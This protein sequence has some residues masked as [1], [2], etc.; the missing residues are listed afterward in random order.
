MQGN[1]PGGGRE[2]ETVEERLRRENE[3]LRH[4]LEALRV[5][6]ESPRAAQEKHWQPS[7]RTIWAIVL[8]L[9]MLLVIAFLAGYIPLQKRRALIVSEATERNEALPRAEVLRVT[10]STHSSELELPGSIQALTEAPL[11]ARADGYIKRRMV[12]IGDRVK[13]GQPLAEIEAPE[14]DEQVNQSKATLEQARAA[15]ESAIANHEQGKAN[16]ELAQ[17]TATRWSNLVKRGVVSKQ[18]NDLH[19]TEYQAQIANVRSLEKAIAAQRS[20]VAA[21]EANLARLKEM[22]NYRTVRAPFDGVIT[23]RNVDIGALVST[24]STLLFR[25]AQTET[26][27]IY[28]NVPQSHASSVRPGQTARLR[29]SNLPG[30]AFAGSVARTANSLDPGSRTMLVEVHVP[31]HDGALFPGMY[32]QVDLSSDRRNPPLLIP[33]DALVVL[34]EGTEVAKLGSGNEVH[35]QRVEVGRDYGDRLEILDGLHDGDIIIPNPGDLAREG[36]RVEPI[37]PKQ[38]QPGK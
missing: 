17:A 29:V 15:L 3:S 34:P 33:S 36:V 30:R 38:S 19:Q 8:L 25:V 35:L 24:G 7:G 14:L 6:P 10:R 28:V 1:I 16:L 21:A 31:N 20:N 32:A 18:D 5:N 22:S 4:Q 23:Q 11:L 26:L 27:R 9:A 37:S 13:A 2:L 12:D